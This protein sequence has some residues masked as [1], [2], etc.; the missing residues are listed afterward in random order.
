MGLDPGTKLGPHEI[1]APLGAGG[2]GQIAESS[3]CD[4]TVEKYSRPRRS[5]S[6]QSVPSKCG[7]QTAATVKS[8]LVESVRNRSIYRRL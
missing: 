4:G 3:C 8:G 5:R 2:I 1:V 6:P 7:L